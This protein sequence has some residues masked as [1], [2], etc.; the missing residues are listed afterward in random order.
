MRMFSSTEDGPWRCR[1]D[2]CPAHAVRYSLLKY[3]GYHEHEWQHGLYHL[4]LKKSKE[5]EEEY[6]PEHWSPLTSGDLS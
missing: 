3:C 1:T 5:L 6:V 4:H 2:G